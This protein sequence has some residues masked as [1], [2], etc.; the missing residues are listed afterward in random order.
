MRKV[1]ILIQYNNLY[2]VYLVF[3]CA[4]HIISN[5]IRIYGIANIVVKTLSVHTTRQL[6][7]NNQ[8]MGQPI[9]VRGREDVDSKAF[10]WFGKN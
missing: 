1:G 8:D 6:N 5:G 2:M 4:F 3:S 7:N 9:H 10:S